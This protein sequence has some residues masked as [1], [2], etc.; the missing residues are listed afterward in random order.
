MVYTGSL[1]T[2]TRA[3]ADFASALRFE[4]LPAEVAI[5]AKRAL[6]DWAA[7]T[8]GGAGEAAAQKVRGVVA[9]MGSGPA[10]VIGSDITTS[11]PFAALANA[12]ASHL[13]DFDDCY[14]PDETTIHMSS[15]LW[16]AILAVGQLRKLSGRDLLA[17]YVAGFEVGARVARAAGSTHYQSSW[18]VTGVCGHVAAAAAVANALKLSPAAATNALGAAA[19]Q[20]AG[21]R[22]VYGSDT[23]A[24]HPGK[25]AM[26]GVLSGLL[27]EAGFTSIDTAIEGTRGLL[28]AVSKAPAPELLIE[29]LGSTWLILE[30]GNKLYPSASLTHAP[31]EAAIQLA[32]SGKLDPDEIE[33]IIV[34]VHPF[35]AAVTAVAQP[36]DGQA[37]RFSTPHCVAVPLA[38]GALL[39]ADFEQYAID[40]P[41][42]RRLRDVVSLV[43]DP[44]MD[45]RG[46]LLTIRT[47]PGETLSVEIE[48]NRGT[49][50]NP[51]SS[52]EL[53]AKFTELSVDRIDPEK[54]KIAL[55]MM[56]SFDSVNDVDQLMKLLKGDAVEPHMIQD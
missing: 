9:A 25:A 45:R 49:P 6:V 42:V 38:R 7:A 21:I 24:I 39:L 28:S 30:N 17:A 53:S 31:I 36:T 40:D 8:L 10:Y 22:E 34:H 3:L 50:T 27:A 47:R 19:T 37:A 44:A 52:E 32:S 26:D 51:L 13:L 1:P 46:C 33:E 5:Y 18:H 4:D 56:W 14:N 35:T 2:K 48:R 23:K 43:A 12:Y 55:E 29:E 41:L 11:A 54:A 15:C 20:G 16:G